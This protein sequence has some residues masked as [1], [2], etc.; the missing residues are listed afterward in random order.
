MNSNEES[1]SRSGD[2]RRRLTIAQPHFKP[3]FSQQD[4]EKFCI[5]EEWTL[6]VM[7]SNIYSDTE[8][9]LLCVVCCENFIFR[10]RQ[11]NPW[12]LGSAREYQL[13]RQKVAQT[14]DLL[15]KE[16][17]SKM[18]GWEKLRCSGKGS[19]L[20][21]KGEGITIMSVI[22]INNGLPEMKAWVDFFFFLFSFNRFSLVDYS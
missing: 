17:P 16:R 10:W 8:V 15:E 3:L 22:S 13:H 14:K 7:S 2:L 19:F 11:I 9:C 20:S 12:P 5:N 1:H 6:I 18:E 21:E 4:T